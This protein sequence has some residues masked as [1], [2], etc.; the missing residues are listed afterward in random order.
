M[1]IGRALAARPRVLMVDEPTGNLDEASAEAVMD[2]ML[3]LT[4]ETNA[5]LLMVTHSTLLA[6]RLSRCQHLSGGR[7][8]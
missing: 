8:E 2:L 6:D 3:G 7:L 4:A 5:G 1:A